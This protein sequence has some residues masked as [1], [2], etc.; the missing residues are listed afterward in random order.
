[1]QSLYNIDLSLNTAKSP[2]RVAGDIYHLSNFPPAFNNDKIYSQLKLT[3]KDVQ[4]DWID[5]KNLFLVIPTPF[6]VTSPPATAATVKS[7]SEEDDI[8]P[9]ESSVVNDTTDLPTAVIDVIKANLPEE[10]KLTTFEDF[11]RK[12]SSATTSSTD[13][14][15]EVTVIVATGITNSSSSTS[16]TAVTDSGSS[17]SGTKNAPFLQKLESAF[18]SIRS[19]LFDGKTTASASKARNDDVSI[20]TA[21][22]VKEDSNDDK[23]VTSK[24]KKPR[25]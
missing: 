16:S 4:I 5:D 1:M 13:S 12:T 3:W 17:S 6:L 22:E 19:S 18:S 7:S 21:A 2:L 15:T 10:W 23:E 20:E 8:I 9:L 14:T 24:S 25:L 11:H